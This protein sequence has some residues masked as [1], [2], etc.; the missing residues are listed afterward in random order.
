MV[1]LLTSV[2]SECHPITL[3]SAFLEHIGPLNKSDE[4]FL[5][6]DG[7]VT[8]IFVMNTFFA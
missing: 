2:A 7:V 1:D 4:H 3:L 8:K 6:S 5:D